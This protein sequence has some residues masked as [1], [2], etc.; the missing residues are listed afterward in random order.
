MRRRTFLQTSSL[1]TAGATVSYAQ[2]SPRL[3]HPKPLHPGDTVALIA[4]STHVSDPDKLEAVVRTVEYF[5]L[6]P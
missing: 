3:L 2:S 4:P 1:I 6:K 5:G